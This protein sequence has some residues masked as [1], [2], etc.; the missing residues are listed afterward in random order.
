M[1]V[2]RG[3]SQSCCSLRAS[4]HLLLFNVHPQQPSD[5]VVVHGIVRQLRQEQLDYTMDGDSADGRGGRVLKAPSPHVKTGQQN[6]CWA[7]AAAAA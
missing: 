1:S 3:L 4:G 2:P 6:Q 7:A 5:L